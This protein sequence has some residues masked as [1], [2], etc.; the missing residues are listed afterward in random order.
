MKF[1]IVGRVERRH[2]LPLSISQFLGKFLSRFRLGFYGW[3]VLWVWC[4]G[5]G[6]WFGVCG[7][8]VLVPTCIVLCN[9]SCGKNSERYMDSQGQE[10][11]FNI[12]PCTAC[13]QIRLSHIETGAEKRCKHKKQLFPFADLWNS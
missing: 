7:W 2:L 5:G 13:E 11:V 6:M 10:C 4:V 1:S 12:E 3:V 9:D 8:A